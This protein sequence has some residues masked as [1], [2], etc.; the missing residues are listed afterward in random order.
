[1]T[2]VEVFF[3]CT[4]TGSYVAFERL[5]RLRKDLDFTIRWRPIFIG[6]V[7]KAANPGVFTQRANMPA[8]KDAYFIKDFEDWGRYTGLTITWPHDFHPLNSIKCMR[9]VVGAQRHGDA[10][11]IIRATFE[12]CWRDG[13]NVN[14]DDVLADVCAA[15]D[16]DP[17]IYFEDLADESVK[18]EL[19]A[20]GE[21]LIARGGFGSPTFF[22]GG[23]DMYW[24][25]D[26]MELV[27]FAIERA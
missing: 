25:N 27:R 13:L 14:D 19:R 26:R 12:A 16:Y 18:A 15:A 7:F 11:A 23:T 17:D 9:G 21:E 22:V 4:S 6:G 3:D 5:C 24:G 20:N 8:V 10:L 1:M 2:E